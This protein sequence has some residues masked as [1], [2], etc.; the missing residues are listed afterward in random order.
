MLKQDLDQKVL[1]QMTK[2]KIQEYLDNKT[3]FVLKLEID[4]KGHGFLTTSYVLC[5]CPDSTSSLT[6]DSISFSEGRSCYF[7]DI[8]G[9]FT[10][11]EVSLKHYRLHLMRD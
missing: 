8:V 3:M 10:L 4:K 9:I 7:K 1:E 11:K 6:E 5:N 2:E